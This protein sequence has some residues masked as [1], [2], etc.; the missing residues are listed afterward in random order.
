M[1][2]QR[3]L[4][5]CTVLC[6]IA[7][8]AQALLPNA[9]VQAKHSLLPLASSTTRMSASTAAQTESQPGR[10]VLTEAERRKYDSSPDA[11]FYSAPKLV[12]H[13]DT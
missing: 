2:L 13:V 4:Q 3:A 9:L 8:S 12:Y 7:H 6:F 10:F 11:Y 5:D 1:R